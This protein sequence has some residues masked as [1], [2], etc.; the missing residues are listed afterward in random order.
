MDLKEYF[1]T[2]TPAERKSYARRC[3][4][5]VEYLIQLVGG[6][7]RASPALAKTLSLESGEKVP[8]SKLRPD[9]WEAA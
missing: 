1:Y 8:L 5:T 2:L 6:H 3:K 9:I 4:T 7:R